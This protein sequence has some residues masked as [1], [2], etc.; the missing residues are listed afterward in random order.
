ML[1][2][3]VDVKQDRCV[4]PPFLA[5]ARSSHLRES[6]QVFCLSLYDMIDVPYVGIVDAFWTDIHYFRAV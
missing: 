1:R 5:P 3:P 4:R 2:E 6:G